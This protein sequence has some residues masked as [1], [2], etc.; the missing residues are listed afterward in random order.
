MPWLHP[1]NHTTERAALV[2]AAKCA[3]LYARLVGAA[4]R[5]YC[6]AGTVTDFTASMQLEPC[7][8]CRRGSERSWAGWWHRGVEKGRKQ[9]KAT[10][11]PSTREE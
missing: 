3:P 1:L 11:G 7:K 8:R 2:G 6:M 10:T 9:R 5:H 4:Q